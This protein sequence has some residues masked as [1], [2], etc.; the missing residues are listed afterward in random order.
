MRGVK[1]PQN[2]TLGERRIQR[3]FSSSDLP[4]A[5]MSSLPLGSFPFPH[6]LLQINSLFISSFRTRP[7]I[8]S[9]TPQR[10]PFPPECF[11]PG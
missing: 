8:L 3:N 10:F 6:G 2:P 7:L 11:F 4:A 1:Q 9:F 5:A